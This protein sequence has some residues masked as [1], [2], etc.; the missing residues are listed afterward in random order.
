M[1]WKMG[2]AGDKLWTA[3]MDAISALGLGES[4]RTGPNPDNVDYGT[5][6]GLM[7]AS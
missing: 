2:N 3:P 7:P 4:G 5:V 6:Q 1:K